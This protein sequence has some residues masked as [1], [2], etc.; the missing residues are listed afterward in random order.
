MTVFGLVD[1]VCYEFESEK[2][3]A[4]KKDLSYKEAMVISMKNWILWSLDTVIEQRGRTWLLCVWP[5][6]RILSLSCPE[7]ILLG[8]WQMQSDDYETLFWQRAS[9]WSGAQ[10]SPPMI[11][12]TFDTNWTDLVFIRSPLP[13]SL[14]PRPS[15]QKFLYGTFS[16]D[17][18]RRISL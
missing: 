8:M 15:P 5:E 14:S 17:T 13:P 7:W 12:L 1:S 9:K 6:K 18:F 3:W 10:A 11:A 4:G 2:S 16:R